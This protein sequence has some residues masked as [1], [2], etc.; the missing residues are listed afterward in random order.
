MRLENRKGERNGMAKLTERR[1]L[2]IRRQAATGATLQSL[3]D[4][5]GV[6]HVAIH[7][8]VTRKTWRHVP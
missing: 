1:V 2:A 4:R 8:V 5:Y 6:S 7:Y 3:A